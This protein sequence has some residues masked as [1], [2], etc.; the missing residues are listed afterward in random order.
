LIPSRLSQGRF[1][2]M[3]V[4]MPQIAAISNCPI[5]FNSC[6]NFRLKPLT[7]EWRSRHVSWNA[8]DRPSLCVPFLI[9][10]GIGW[11]RL[12]PVTSR[13]LQACQ[14]QILPFSRSANHSKVPARARL[15]IYP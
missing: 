4:L 3:L 8:C 1:I 2:T 6:N 11:N 7:L 13:K 5:L 12:S 9:P 10:R 14:V 15:G